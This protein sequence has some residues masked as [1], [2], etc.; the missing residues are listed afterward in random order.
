MKKFAGILL[1]FLTL[2]ACL[3][4]DILDEDLTG[5]N[6][7][8]SEFYT[9][10]DFS[11]SFNFTVKSTEMSVITNETDTLCSPR[12]T[13]HLEKSFASKLE[14]NWDGE[15]YLGSINLTDDLL[16]IFT[17]GGSPVPCNASYSVSQP[18]LN[19]IDPKTQRVSLSFTKDITLPIIR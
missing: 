3:K 5:S 19:L 18:T 1:L 4:N 7:K 11:E 17:I 8:Q 13:V 14:T 2:S 16:Q 15:I 6:F 12:F 9:S 10:G